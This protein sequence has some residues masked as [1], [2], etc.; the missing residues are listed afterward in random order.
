MSADSAF[1]DGRNLAIPLEP[2]LQGMSL[3]Q[4]RELLAWLASDEEVIRCVVDFICGEDDLGWA[5]GDPNRRAAILA[6]VEDTQL[7]E[8]VHYGWYPW[9]EATRK[10][11]DIRSQ[12]HLYWVLYHQIDPEISRLVFGELRRLGVESNYTT[13]VADEEVA[14]VRNELDTALKAMRL[15]PANVEGGAE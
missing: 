6:R 11:K 4:K 13:K 12:E 9:V 14:M 2:L 3:E 5:M 8:G 7:R 10:I 1:V 15:P